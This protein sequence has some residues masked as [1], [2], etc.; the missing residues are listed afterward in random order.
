M[1]KKGIPILNKGCDIK[2]IL[3]GK[4]PN[5]IQV[6]KWEVALIKDPNTPK[7]HVR[8]EVINVVA[9]LGRIAHICCIIFIYM[10]VC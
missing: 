4:I 10:V 3:Q 5:I 2:E 9:V 7:T 1:T 6:R 8:R